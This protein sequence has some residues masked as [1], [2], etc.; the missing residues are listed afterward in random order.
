MSRTTE[1][2]KQAADRLKPRGKLGRKALRGWLTDLK[3]MRS[4]GLA[5]KAKRLGREIAHDTAVGAHDL[6]KFTSQENQQG[7][8]EEIRRAEM[9]T[10]AQKMLDD[11]KAREHREQ[12]AAFKIPL[13]RT[14]DST[15]IPNLT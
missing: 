1:A 2:C 8:A 3:T 9:V 5:L 11:E 14:T 13:L 4:V 15:P 12:V 10:I 7:D 6:A